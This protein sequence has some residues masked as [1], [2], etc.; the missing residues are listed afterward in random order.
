MI[1]Y[2]DERFRINIYLDTNI[3]VDYIEGKYPLL[4]QSINFLA[5]CPWV[6]LR[7]SHYVLF[8]FTEVRKYN[9]FIHKIPDIDLEKWTKFKVKQ[10]N[11]KVDPSFDYKDYQTEISKTINEELEILH[12]DLKLNFDEHVL[13]EALVYPANNLCLSTRI[14][15]EDCLVMISCMHPQVSLK[16]SQC[17]LLSRDKQYNDAF[18]EDRENVC[19]L[20]ENIHLDIPDMLKASHLQINNEGRSVNLYLNEG[21][22]FDL[23]S[24]WIS[25]IRSYIIK[26]MGDNYLG[27]T[28]VYGIKS[29][30]NECVYFTMDNPE[31]VLEKSD[32][33]IF[34]SPDLEIIH[35]IV[36]NFKYWNN[37]EI[38]LPYVNSQDPK[39]SFKPLGIPSNVLADIR[40]EGWLVFYDNE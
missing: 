23:E 32:G 29:P 14:S 28:Y 26:K 27:K 13:H 15:K 25:L 39:Y 11:W 1:G 20:F 5:N 3:L 8:E 30:E 35:S 40:K 6:T 31:K 12:Q 10:N 33:L 19:K 2:V 9:L 17:I 24:F 18:S 7:S 37:K 21:S 36:V 38:N 22:P 4:C 34:I 16:L